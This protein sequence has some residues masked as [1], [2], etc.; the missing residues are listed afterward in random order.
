M[1][2]SSGQPG[3]LPKVSAKADPSELSPLAEPT[4]RQGKARKGKRPEK[5]KVYCVCRKD[6]YTNARAHM[7]VCAHMHPCT[8]PCSPRAQ[9]SPGCYT[10]LWRTQQRL[11]HT[12]ETV[13][14]L[15]PKTAELLSP[16]PGSGGDRL[17][18]PQLT[19]PLT[20]LASQF[21]S[22]TCPPTLTWTISLL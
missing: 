13:S 10:E 11:Q 7:Y 6:T 8:R 19:L 18:C 1:D 4:V 20:G 14:P 21:F 22:T 5:G 9:A 17:P 12:S 3:M 15:V 2:W 16:S